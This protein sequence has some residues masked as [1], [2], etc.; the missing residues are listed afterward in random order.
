MGRVADGGLHFETD[1][2]WLD[3][4]RAWARSELRINRVW[5]FGS[6]VSGVR[7]AKDAPTPIPDLDVAYEILEDPAESETAYTFHFFRADRWRDDLQRQLP[8]PIDLQFAVTDD[9]DA[10]VP[11]FVAAAGRLIYERPQA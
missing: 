8:V 11:R 9:P 1:P 6:R 10:H 4:L 3:V 2:Q 7:R 5:I